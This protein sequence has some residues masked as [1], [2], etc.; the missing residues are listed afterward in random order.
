[1]KRKGLFNIKV[2]FDDENVIKCKADKIEEV[3]EIFTNLK[4][5]FR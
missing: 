5:K 3:D 2:D 4:K 1:M